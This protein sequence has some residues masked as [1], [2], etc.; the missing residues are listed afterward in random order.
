MYSVDYISLTFPVKPS[1]IDWEKWRE[2]QTKYYDKI[3]FI[4]ENYGFN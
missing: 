2:S 4:G 3:I 1:R